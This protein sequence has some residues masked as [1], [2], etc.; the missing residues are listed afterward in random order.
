MQDGGSLEQRTATAPALEP[1]QVEFELVPGEPP[2]AVRL[3]PG[4]TVAQARQ[5]AAEQAG[6]VF[7]YP[8]RRALKDLYPDWV[9]PDA[10][11][12]ESVSGDEVFL[13]SHHPMI[14][15]PWATARVRL[16]DCRAAAES[17]VCSATADQHSASKHLHEDSAALWHGPR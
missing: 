13:I 4:M 10:N 5:L 2:V 6:L 12:D 9:D 16:P 14:V 8:P 11:P 1:Q 7:M 17:G 3:L 15:W